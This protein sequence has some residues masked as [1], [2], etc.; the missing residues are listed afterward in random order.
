MKRLGFADAIYIVMIQLSNWTRIELF[1]FLDPIDHL[2]NFF[3]DRRLLLNGF[4]QKALSWE[5]VQKG[6]DC[7]E[8]ALES[9]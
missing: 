8:T 9:S 5:M 3:M 6:I 2:S 7:L 1:F 4:V